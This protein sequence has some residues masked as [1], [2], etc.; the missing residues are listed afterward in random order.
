M[1]ITVKQIKKMKKE[2]KTQIFHILHE[3]RRCPLCGEIGKVEIFSD[4]KFPT[5]YHKRCKICGVQFE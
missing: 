5:I 4:K 3:S 1:N 2:E